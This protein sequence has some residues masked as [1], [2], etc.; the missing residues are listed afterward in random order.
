MQSTQLPFGSVAGTQGMVTSQYNNQQLAVLPAHQL[1]QR[2]QVSPLLPLQVIQTLEKKQQVFTAFAGVVA[3]NKAALE[4]DMDN[5]LKEL[6]LVFEDLKTQLFQKMD[7]QAAAFQKIFEQYERIAYD[8]SDWAEQKIGSSNFQYDMKSSVNDLLSHGLSQARFQKQKA[9]DIEKSLLAIKQK[10]DS[11]KLLELSDEINALA[12]ERNQTLYVAEEARRFYDDVKATLKLKAGQLNQSRVVPPFAFGPL[13]KPPAEKGRAFFDQEYKNGVATASVPVP[14]PPMDTKTNLSG[15]LQQVVGREGALG[16]QTVRSEVPVNA[17]SGVK[18]N[19][20]AVSGR[21]SLGQSLRNNAEPKVGIIAQ[22][23]Q[24]YSDEMHLVNPSIRQEKDF[25]FKVK[26]RINCVLSL[27]SNISLFGAE[28]GSIVILNTTTN[29]Q[30]VVKAHTAPVFGLTK[31][32]ESLVVSSAK[33]PDLALKL[34]DFGPILAAAA[35]SDPTRPPGNVLLVCVLNGLTD[36]AVGHAFIAE[37]L[38]LAVGRDGQIVIWDWKTGV[39]VTQSKTDAAPVAAFTLF[40][41]RESFAVAT[42][43]GFVQCYGLQRDGRNFSIVKQSEF[44]EAFPVAALHSFRGNSDVLIVALTSGDVRLL[45]KRTRA[46]YHTIIGCKS[47]LSFFVLNSVRADSTIYL[48]SLEPF[49]FKLA[50]IDGRDFAYVNTASSTNFKFE[51]SG[52]PN[53]QIVDSVPKERLSF[54]T[55]NNGKEPNEAILWSL[56]AAP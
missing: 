54:L 31:A 27:I 55:V 7:D 56:N 36:T 46:V 53:W 22:Q 48:L 32:N 42:A 35:S 16:G 20:S 8:C 25:T 34:W 49:G 6:I 47:P 15:Y 52:W 26:S 21:E 37:N 33:A 24:F 38:I 2:I 29:A 12:D 19:S 18:V 17:Q 9:D 5:F 1:A 30:S 43:E 14:P 45:N 11:S 13:T 3:K 40:S 41:D 23:N 10:F 39:P 44:R 51:K 28:D 4:R 50:D